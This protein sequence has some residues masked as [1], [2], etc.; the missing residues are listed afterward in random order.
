MSVF[1]YSRQPFLPSTSHCTGKDEPKEVCSCFGERFP[2][3]PQTV[4]PGLQS[5]AHT[6]QV[7]VPPRCQQVASFSSALRRT[8]AF[9]SVLKGAAITGAYQVLI[10]VHVLRLDE[11]QFGPSLPHDADGPAGGRDVAR[12]TLRHT[13]T[14]QDRLSRETHGD[15][16]LQ[17]ALLPRPPGTPPLIPTNSGP[18]WML[19]AV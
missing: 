2:R 10:H 11:A 14:P 5:Q 17:L 9:Q 18:L 3:E 6:R 8:F 19:H 12:S 16:L 13:I 7:T 1:R 15:V 4:R